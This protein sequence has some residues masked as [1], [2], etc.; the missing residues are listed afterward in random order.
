MAQIPGIT[1]Q[2]LDNYNP[3]AALDRFNTL[4]DEIDT[5]WF[6]SSQRN[7]RYHQ[8]TLLYEKYSIIR[9]LFNFV[10][11]AYNIAARFVRKINTIVHANDRVFFL[12]LDPLDEGIN[13]VYL[14]RCVNNNGI[15][16]YSKV[17]TTKRKTLQRMK[18]HLRGYAKDGVCYIYVDRLWNCGDIDPEGLESEFRAHYIGKHKGTFRKNDRFANVNFDLDEA[19]QIAENYFNRYR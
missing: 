9:S 7:Y 18:E 13:Q 2:Y 10:K 4:F 17:G 6:S 11:N 1:Q 19:D 3:N 5:P 12:N 16:V 15:T 14:I 8:M